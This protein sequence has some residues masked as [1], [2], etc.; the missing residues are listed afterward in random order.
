MSSNKMRVVCKLESLAVGGC[1]LEDS[2][3]QTSFLSLGG[4]P[5]ATVGRIPTWG[6]PASGPTSALI[7]T[8]H[9]TWGK[10]FPWTGHHFPHL[11]NEG[12]V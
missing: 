11:Y 2:L 3:F 4:V 12:M 1:P 7:P 8:S 9:G 5:G 10:L 6:P